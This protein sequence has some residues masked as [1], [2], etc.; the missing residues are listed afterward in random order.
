MRKGH[1]GVLV[2]TS[3]GR[4]SHPRCCPLL[5]PGWPSVP[6]DPGTPWSSSRGPDPTLVC[7][8]SGCAKLGVGATGAEYVLL[9]ELHGEEPCGRWWPT[10][11]LAGPCRPDTPSPRAAGGMRRGNMGH[12]TRIANAV[13]Q[14]LE[15]GPLQSQVSEVFRGERLQARVSLPAV[16]PALWPSAGGT[17][18][19]AGRSA[20]LPRVTFPLGLGRSRF[21]AEPCTPA[22][23]VRKSSPEPCGAPS[24]RGLRPLHLGLL[25]APCMSWTPLCSSQHRVLG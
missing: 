11:G 25:R 17:G 23:A 15:G 3:Q 14:N 12:L 10:L 2:A 8:A 9:N 7:G 16:P 20:C 19:A 13:V 5:V 1:V 6:L 21:P 18:P 24:H 22:C 4:D